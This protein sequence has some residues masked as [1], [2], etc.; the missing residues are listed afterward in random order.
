MVE[1]RVAFGL[2]CLILG[3]MA[4]LAGDSKTVI[5]FC[6]YGQIVPMVLL[7]SNRR[8]DFLSLGRIVP[9]STS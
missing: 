8:T 1:F 7:G 5:V 3:L 4:N 6:G 9:H 2:C